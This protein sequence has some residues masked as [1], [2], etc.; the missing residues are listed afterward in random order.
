[1]G[2]PILVT[3]VGGIQTVTDVVID[4]ATTG[5]QLSGDSSVVVRNLLTRVV[6][7]VQAASTGSSA[8]GPSAIT[9][10]S[11]SCSQG[12]TGINF[13][14]GGKRYLIFAD[15]I[16]ACDSGIFL[17]GLGAGTTVLGTVIRGGQFGI[18][19]AQ[20]TSSVLIDSTGIS[21][22]TAAGILLSSGQVTAT[23]NRIESNAQ[24]GVQVVTSSFGIP[25]L[26]QNSFVGNAG[27]AIS[28]SDTV[29]ASS[30]W[31]GAS[32]GAC[33]PGADC[34][35]GRVSEANPL[36]APPGGLPGL[37]APF[38]AAGV[39][40]TS[41]VT[42]VASSSARVGAADLQSLV[43]RAAAV[44]LRRLE[45]HRAFEAERRRRHAEVERAAIQGRSHKVSKASAPKL[46]PR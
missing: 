25:Q 18:V 16:S 34:V 4:S 19:V 14:G 36:A 17:N 15:T 24:Y 26:H 2:Y 1:V 27:F 45:R 44:E 9:G 39:S 6:V 3:G 46:S 43:S 28:A 40:R 42:P 38:F 31:W 11:I 5:I 41:A 7:G 10:N 32:T 30:N 21:G 33:T 12:G 13:A 20:D 29:D 23:R 35:S 8:R 22:T 37:V